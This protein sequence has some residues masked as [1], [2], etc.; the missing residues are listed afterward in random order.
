MPDFVKRLRE[1]AAKTEFPDTE[2]QVSNDNLPL[3]PIN[4]F[5]DAANAG[6]PNPA[7]DG[8]IPDDGSKKMTDKQQNQEK[9]KLFDMGLNMPKSD[10]QYPT[11]DI[12]KEYNRPVQESIQEGLNRVKKTPSVEEIQ[13][14]IN[15]GLSS[16]DA[17]IEKEG[18]LRTKIFQAIF[19]DPNIGMQG[20]K[21]D[22]S[23]N[24]Y[25]IAKSILNDAQK[26]INAPKKGANFATSFGSGAS[27]AVTDLDFWTLGV[28]AI[29][30]TLQIIPLLNKYDSGKELTPS[31]EAVMEALLIRSMA[32]FA[33]QGDISNWYKGGSIAANAATFMVPFA[34]TRNVANA[35]V[36]GTAA[37]TKRA[38]TK[39][40][41]KK[42]GKELGEKQAAKLI[43]DAS[44]YLA[45]SPIAKKA[46]HAVGD[47]T[48]GSAVRTPLMPSTYR[49]VFEDISPD[50]I[51][52]DS[53][54]NYILED[55]KTVAQAIGN[56]VIEVASES[57]G[58]LIGAPFSK[59]GNMIRK[60]GVSKAIMNTKAGDVYK[61][62]SGS[63][64]GMV[65]DELRKGGYNGFLEELG[66]EHFGNLTRYAFGINSV[67]EFKDF[68]SKDNQLA[69]AIGFLPLT[70]SSSMSSMASRGKVYSSYN[71][72]NKTLNNHLSSMNI[73]PEQISAVKSQLSNSELM[74]IDENILNIVNSLGGIN[75]DGTFNDNGKNLST[76]LLNFAGAKVRKDALDEASGQT[77]DKMN[78]VVS[79]VDL[80]ENNGV[81]SVDISDS[82]GGI[83]N[84][85]EIYDRQTAQS[86]YQN[87]VNLYLSPDSQYKE[88]L[89]Q[90]T[91][92]QKMQASRLVNAVST[93]EMNADGQFEVIQGTVTGGEYAGKKA[94]VKSIRGDLAAVLINENGKL[95]EAA[96][97]VSYF[98]EEERKT[99]NEAYQERVSSI[100]ETVSRTAVATEEMTIDNLSKE[101][102]TQ[103]DDYSN[104]KAGDEITYNGQTARI[105][106]DAVTEQ[107][108]HIGNIE[109]SNGDIIEGIDLSKVE[110]PKK[111]NFSSNGKD[112]EF[113]A[114]YETGAFD[115]DF[116]SVE[117]AEKAANSMSVRE[118]YEVV[119]SQI[120]DKNNPIQ[121]KGRVSVRKKQEESVEDTQ[122]EAAERIADKIISGKTDWSPEELQFQL[123]YPHKIEDVLRRR[124]EQSSKLPVSN[125]PIPPQEEWIIG[126]NSSDQV[127]MGIFGNDK[128][129][130]RFVDDV[131]IYDLGSHVEY[132]W[133]GHSKRMPKGAF[134]SQQKKLAE[135]YLAQQEQKETH[136]SVRISEEQA[137]DL[138]AQMEASAE[139]MPVLELTP[140]NWRS[141]FGENGMV[142]TPIGEV[143]MGESQLEKLFFNNRT[144]EFGM[145]KPTLT[146]PDVIVG[147]AIEAKKGQTTERP[148]S[149]LF[150]KTFTDITGQKYTFFE[151]VTVQKD[152]LEVSVSSHIADKK[153]I[154][155]ELTNGT[156]AYNKFA[157]RS[158]VYLPENHEGQPDIVPTQ[159]NQSNGKDTQKNNTDTGIS[160]EQRIFYSSLPKDKKGEF[161]IDKFTPEQLIQYSIIDGGTEL[162]IR[163]AEG[164]S[165]KA[166]SKIGELSKK[167]TQLE[168]AEGADILKSRQKIKPIQEQLQELTTQKDYFDTYIKTEKKR[169]Y[170]EQVEKTNKSYKDFK[171]NELAERE[172]MLNRQGAAKKET[173][174]ETSGTTLK[175]ILKKP[176]ELDKRVYAVSEAMAARGDNTVENSILLKIA[177][178]NKFTWYDNGIERGFGR[179]L[180][181][182]KS[183]SE[184]RSHVRIIDRKKGITVEKFA[185]NIAEELGRDDVNDIRSKILAIIQGG[186]RS[187]TMAVEALESVYRDELTTKTDEKENSIRIKPNLDMDSYFKE[188][189][190]MPFQ[191]EINDNEE[192]LSVNAL[193]NEELG[194]LT[195]EN[196]DSKIFNLGSPS[197]ILLS[198]GIENK[199]LR[200]Y[201]SK[202]KSKAEKHGFK[203]I[204]LK[205]LP[206]AIA[207]PIAVFSGSVENSHAILTELKIGSKNVLATVRVGKE[208]DIDFNMISSTYGKD[209][210][211]VIGWI[212]NGKLT[213]S[214]KEKTLAYMGAPAL[215]AGA[216]NKQELISAAK[217]VQNF[218]NPTIG[219]QISDKKFTTINKSQF[220]T[221]IDLLKKTGLA[222]EVVTDPVEMR[223]VL[224]KELGTRMHVKGNPRSAITNIRGSWTKDKIVK[225]LKKAKKADTNRSEESIIRFISQFD[226]PQELREH[227]FYHGT[228]S[229]VSRG[230]Y[231]SITMSER[232]AE[233]RGGGGYG[234]RYYA[235]SLSS[236]KKIAGNFSGQ[237][238]S[239]SIYPVLLNKYATVID[240]PEIS[241]SAEI[242]DIIVDL[243]NRG[244]D[245]VR[246]G[247]QNADFGTE[248]ELAV[249]NPYAISVFHS[250]AETHRVFGGV[251]LDEITDDELQS[252]INN[253]KRII[254][255]TENFRENNKDKTKYLYSSLDK[256]STE[257]YAKLKEEY[258]QYKNELSDTKR[259]LRGENP[260]RLMA[261]SKGEVYGFV[262]PDRT[263]YLDGERMNANTPIHEFG[264]LWNT[265]VK[266]NNPELWDKGAELIKNSPYMEAVNSDPNYAGLSEE[267]KA[268]EAMARAIGDRGET[269]I[270]GKDNKDSFAQRIKD[271]INEVWEWIGS[272]LGIRSLSPEQIQDLSLEQFTDGA[273]ADLLRGNNLSEPG[274]TGLKDLQDYDF[275]VT[276]ITD[277]N[278][279]EMQQIKEMSVA[280]GTFMKAP[281]GKPTNLNERQWLQVRTGKFREWFGEWEKASKLSQIDNLTAIKVTDKNLTA[282]QAKEIYQSIGEAKNK[283]DN[284]SVKFINSTFGK[285]TRHKGV[286]TKQIIPQLKTVFENAVPIY[287][288]TETQKEGHKKHPNFVGY[289]NYLGKIEIDG[290]EYFVRFTVQQEKTNSKTYNPNQLHSTFISG[291]EL[292]ETKTALS[293]PRL[294]TGAKESG[295]VDTKLQQFFE[296][297][298]QAQVNS[299]KVVDE[300]GEP[301]VV[302]HGAGFV[303]PDFSVFNTDFKGS[304]FSPIKEMAEEYARVG[305]KRIYE[306]FLNLKNPKE[307][308]VKGGYWYNP[309]GEYINSNA[310][311]N[312]EKWNNKS[313]SLIFRNMKD[314]GMKFPSDV[315]VAF[316]PDQIKS[317]TS[318]NGNF[319]S[320]SEDIRFMFI[321]EKGVRNYAENAKDYHSVP[322]KSFTEWWAK[323]GEAGNAQLIRQ[324]EA[325]ARIDNL[326]VAREMERIMSEPGFPQDLKD[327]QDYRRKIK[328]ATGWERGADGKWRYETG[329]IEVDINKIDLRRRVT[330]L[331]DI[332]DGGENAEF[333]MIYPE[334][335][336]IKITVKD[337]AH[338]DAHWDERNHEIAFNRQH[339][340]KGN[341]EWN[342]RAIVHE[343]QH[344][345]QGI[346]GFARGDSP[347]RKE[348]VHN[349]EMHKKWGDTLT[350][351]RYIKDFGFNKGSGVYDTL[352][353]FTK[354]QIESVKR[355]KPE[356]AVAKLQETAGEYEKEANREQEI[357]KDRYMRT[358]GEAEARNAENRMNMKAEERRASL[359]EETEDVTR[360]DQIF[361]Q[362]SLTANVL[363]GKDGRLYFIDT[364]P[365]TSSYLNEQEDIPAIRFQIEE[366]QKEIDDFN[367]LFGEAKEEHLNA[368]EKAR[369]A[370]TP[371]AMA[372][373]IIE[374][375]KK[376]KEA[377]EA[378]DF[379]FDAMDTA[380]ERLNELTPIDK[381]LADI[382]PS[383]WEQIIYTQQDE[384]DPIRRLQERVKALGGKV[385]DSSN[386]YEDKNHSFGRATTLIEKFNDKE[387]KDIV[388]S[389]RAI[390]KSNRL[391]LSPLHVKWVQT[392]EELT[393]VQK[394]NI[395]L[396][397][398]D[399]QEAIE[400]DLP[401]R[402][403]E[404]FLQDTGMLHA[405]YIKRFERTISDS[406]LENLHKAIF[407]A[408]KYS[409]NIQKRYGLINKETYDK[410]SDRKYYVPERGWQERDMAGRDTY[411]INNK[412]DGGNNPFNPA[413]IKAKG[414]TSL[415]GDP[416][417][418]IQSIAH[419]SILSAEK[420]RTKQIA[421]NFVLQNEKLGK[422]K[423]LFGF[424]RVW[425]V[426]TGEK[427]A[428][429]NPVY[430]EVYQRPAQ[431]LFDEGK[432]KSEVNDAYKYMRT[433]AE[434][435]QHRVS[436]F[437]NGEKYVL[438]FADERVSN[439]L[440]RKTERNDIK[441]F[442]ATARKGTRYLSG[443]MTHYNP[444]F[445][446]WNLARDTG[447]SLTSNWCEYGL[448]FTAE[449]VKT[450]GTPGLQEALLNY[451]T[452]GNFSNKKYGNMLSD[453]FE[454]G[455]ATGFS[456]LKDVDQLRKTF[457]S[458]VNRGVAGEVSKAILNGIPKAFG[459]MTEYSE[460]LVRFSQYAALRN[461]GKSRFEATTGAK[462]ISVNFNRKGAMRMGTSF[463]AFWNSSV[464]GT[465]KVLGLAWKHKGKFAA[466]SGM[467]FAGGFLNTLFA[468]DDP[469]QE[470]AWGEYDRMQNIIIGNFKIPLPHVLRAF[471][472]AGVQLAL[473]MQDRKSTGQAIFDATA[474]A[475]GDLLPID[476]FNVLEYDEETESIGFNT[477]GLSE[478]APTNVRPIVDIIANRTFTGAKVHPEPFLRSQ[479]ETIPRAFL[480][481]RD[482]N[483]YLQD[484]SYALLE[485]GG[486]YRRVK[487]LY[488]P[489]GKVSREFDI[490]P[491][492]IEHILKGYTG[493][494]GAFL[495][496]MTH[497]IVNAIDG[498][499]DPSTV[500]V[501]NRAYK[502]YNEDNVFLRNKYKAARKVRNYENQE[503]EI[504]KAI[505]TAKSEE[506]DAAVEML[507][508]RLN[509]LE[510]NQ[511]NS[512]E[513]GKDLLRE[514][515]NEEEIFDT[516]KYIKELEKLNKEW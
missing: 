484:F 366:S 193:F 180:G 119:V 357:G 218:E 324:A 168:K 477:Y 211:G 173:Q 455:A 448:G 19:P 50:V 99:A 435:Q 197:N 96:I 204:D 148:S 328:M 463:F 213:Y 127:S 380:G 276:G 449:F 154:A 336:N 434:S 155:Q 345:I 162:A 383:I 325:Q 62:I 24:Q 208:P 206:I 222:K 183:K 362:D 428:N 485:S 335:G 459:A 120:P 404:G 423:G 318:N 33:R 310:V 364:V 422:A 38:I 489:E 392:G 305:N 4:T 500:P 496:D 69:M 261:T 298:K 189:P 179:E 439:G 386:M 73:T 106:T 369:T 473:A 248:K 461:S 344:A 37:L 322:S 28:S 9:M 8:I 482:V 25:S 145:I 141:E 259:K 91:N 7:L 454:D 72:A 381:E 446:L 48:V 486:G 113:T 313:T 169:I 414:R 352:S 77:L 121:I 294:L 23:L 217:I 132:H 104:K 71:K 354:Q 254:V 235:I 412:N 321:G 365:H 30:E 129:V 327:L 164:E 433:T 437:S 165:K 101:G 225:E 356:N 13:N 471:W 87:A 203:Y 36:K 396:Q 78:G 317:A 216:S 267:Q 360:E 441:K 98:Q 417:S 21:S 331:T 234:D 11:I 431:D 92:E 506:D 292:Y 502:P 416:I 139:N 341:T 90:A 297:A 45:K 452:T 288:E 337:I 309:T 499:F 470:R 263:V 472:G 479:D 429:G 469:D 68:Y 373:G 84:H 166:Q 265:F 220:N 420:N 88:Q 464:Q 304:F 269:V 379:L 224:E 110:N 209:L 94:F 245:A 128:G 40:A 117:A 436:V 170:D 300:N 466:V 507:E 252:T 150:V 172:A 75:Q 221:L 427:D 178:G 184:M 137:T 18:G 55:G 266:E 205:D 451:V 233:Q 219:T 458:E 432:V 236:S 196:A 330:Y 246:I 114:N 188:Y 255:G 285:I 153:A 134:L 478:F 415:A 273:V 64:F 133:N 460:L 494:V 450:M 181:L 323:Y 296:I 353:D 35:A 287:F 44:A 467:L 340:E 382:R 59:L 160:E 394:I 483:K 10:I 390:I 230:L 51:G 86:Y 512:Y 445:A 397:A 126:V 135:M 410:F 66:E 282:E 275:D 476:V 295:I 149:Y 368:S 97:P 493:G 264:H 421:L 504:K 147:T 343:I 403:Q 22:Q 243:W 123:N 377:S 453:F 57:A 74:N 370:K 358:A 299:S 237:S 350:A 46:V 384:D 338:G 307:I 190:Y 514:L 503:R 53:E 239:V 374:A 279:R 430:K 253:A 43:G 229:Y 333:F 277:A 102:L 122:E 192:L 227:L 3:N 371:E 156:I 39:F 401:N 20:Y 2:Q 320:E 82:K 223:E 93:T 194:R 182:G 152:G 355:M 491:S 406:Q 303:S 326:E 105:V 61:S 12:S 346:E 398:K 375:N 367:A 199:P 359:A 157:N 419:S 118:G 187:R 140:D 339:F 198:A 481:K 176:T 174:K 249:I 411:Y 351:I 136:E 89:E 34:A 242:E 47:M 290:K 5:V 52:R 238:R 185:E 260:I 158:E 262:T 334:L 151:S 443:V 283:S 286:D 407:N 146:N 474:F 497:T 332:A 418:F 56:A 462:N 402:G 515:N 516:K 257:E 389:Y 425:Y 447:L 468:P 315:F 395:Y 177:E 26:T 207:N 372:S 200:L 492:N 444:S 385:E 378:R 256:M 112:V 509:L 280:N 400:M 116:P 306:V 115:A 58:G 376:A 475:I 247:D 107:G 95:K 131:V 316:N 270:A 488:T 281:N 480:G 289:H 424:D 271:W 251:K 85:R 272:K 342:R 231:P 191:I 6:N 408:T 108:V 240:M 60:S 293:Y 258:Q 163:V 54:G 80:K 329:D 175:T 388:D 14:S 490:N 349:A 195:S 212:N 186:I 510:S 399:I 438:W 513:K 210:K 1:A 505:R 167:V 111:L 301:M 348:N 241:D 27:D 16:L 161:D 109:L 363:K 125:I 308:D 314:G 171:R 214:N 413:L 226:S 498:K 274:F 440:N 76:A 130:S 311:A 17:K 15:E 29:G 302:Y 456:F 501:L 65:A 511:G 124:Q 347:G 465:A 142:E 32:E 250:G 67:E 442:E 79:K 244:V 70:A 457:A 41:T 268:D 391:K 278:A 508:E 291:I 138:I 81:Y 387:Y 487:F 495:A 159:A 426:Q 31:E 361:L 201:G 393:P 232:D 228:G 284:R 143:K 42:L 215:I 100:V 312:I 83:L 202:L 144:S 409:L 405:D 49:S 63:A 319:D 103:T